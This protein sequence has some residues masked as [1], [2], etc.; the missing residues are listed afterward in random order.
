MGLTSWTGNKLR[1]SDIGIAKNYLDHEELEALNRIVTAYLEFAKLQAK[2]RKPMYMR[3]WIVK[4]DD[5]LNLSEQEILTHAGRINHE[6]AV[7]KAETEYEQ[8][9]KQQLSQPSEAEKHFN[10]AVE[11]IKQLQPA[12]KKRI[13]K[14]RRGGR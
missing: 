3:D 11:K 1:K 6:T 7:E 8:Y 12:K 10:S 14:N 9:R 13:D 5:F 4:L 2:G